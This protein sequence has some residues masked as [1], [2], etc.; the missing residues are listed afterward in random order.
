MTL[1]GIIRVTFRILPDNYHGRQLTPKSA[2]SWRWNETEADLVFQFARTVASVTSSFVYKPDGSSLK[3]SP[4]LFG[5]WRHTIAG[6]SGGSVIHW[7]R[8]YDSSQGL[9]LMR[10]RQRADDVD[11]VWRLIRVQQSFSLPM[12]RLRLQ[13]LGMLLSSTIEL[14]NVY[15]LR[16]SKNQQ[17]DIAAIVKFIVRLCKVV[18]MW[19]RYAWCHGE[20]TADNRWLFRLSD[21]RNPVAQLWPGLRLCETVERGH[22]SSSW[23]GMLRTWGWIRFEGLF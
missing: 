17:L 4:H 23:A 18:G 21:Y 3:S 2:L 7:A 13:S 6:L 15:T 8:Q 14:L 20:I 5:T 19:N 10:S 22:A 16:W 12:T 11:F 1:M 9:C